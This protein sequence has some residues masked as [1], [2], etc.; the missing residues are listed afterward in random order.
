MLKK[1]SLYAEE[2]FTQRSL[3]P[4]ELLHTN[5]L[6]LLL[7]QKLLHREVFTQ[8]ALTHSPVYTQKLLHRE[9]FTQ[10]SFAHGSFHTQRN[11]YTN[12]L[13]HRAAFTHRRKLLHKEVFTER[14]TFTHKSF[15]T[16]KSL[17][18]GAFTRSNKLKLA[19]VL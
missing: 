13:S 17:Y 10:R 5:G 14:E 15:Y 18:R 6:E 9:A 16:E 1:T 7:S 8:R 19:A 11:L 12:A 3:Y 4:K 2:G